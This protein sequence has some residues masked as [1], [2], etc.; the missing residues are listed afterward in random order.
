[1]I[2]IISIIL[3]I[4]FTIIAM[5]P[6]PSKEELLFYK[7]RQTNIININNNNFYDNIHKLYIQDNETIFNQI[8]QESR[9]CQNIIL[10]EKD[11]LLNEFKK[12]FKIKKSKWQTY[13]DL[14]QALKSLNININQQIPLTVPYNPNIPDNL[15]HIIKQELANLFI[16]TD[17]INIYMT[18]DITKTQF[19][20]PQYMYTI[21]DNIVI[22]ENNIKSGIIVL[23]QL[24]Q[25]NLTIFTLFCR[26]SA[27]A[28]FFND[29]IEWETMP[30]FF[31]FFNITP[32]Q[33]Y[34]SKAYQKALP[35]FSSHPILLMASTSPENAQ[36]LLLY[37]SEN[38]IPQ[39][40][41]KN[42]NLLS[43]IKTLWDMFLWA[44]KKVSC[45]MHYN[46]AHNNCIK[47]ENTIEIIYNKRLTKK[48]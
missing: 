26:I 23:P 18:D 33:A 40:S 48:I 47:N 8:D 37:T 31:S 22:I 30:F 10:K 3:I 20:A 43:K 19:H 14:T 17:H 9:D 45:E 13:I 7:N 36:N 28:I 34:Q 27:H 11:A 32:E 24:Y 16:N 1:M 29:A 12:E 15:L 4:P 6:L 35:T 25:N 42:F 38:Y 41:L 21:E 44:Q 2:K 39:F 46:E 5:N